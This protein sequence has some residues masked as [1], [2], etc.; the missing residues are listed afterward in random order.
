M[1]FYR[2]GNIPLPSTTAA[3]AVFLNESADY[4]I[5]YFVRNDNNIFNRFKSRPCVA[6]KHRL[7]PT[8]VS[9]QANT[10]KSLGRKKK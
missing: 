7:H 3:R 1:L 5:L 2:T 9:K 8:R 4:I 6:I 10:E